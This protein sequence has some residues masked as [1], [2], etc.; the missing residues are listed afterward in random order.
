MPD[1]K[2][3]KETSNTEKSNSNKDNSI[4][5]LIQSVKD[6]NKNPNMS[7]DEIISFLK[8]YDES[9]KLFNDINEKEL[10]NIIL[11]IEHVCD[12]NQ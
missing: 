10:D 9:K 12:S 4:K 7:C 8:N 11:A 3:E 1:K 6:N 5:I 2:I